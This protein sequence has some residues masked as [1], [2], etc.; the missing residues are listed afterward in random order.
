[1]K[2]LSATSHRP[3][4]LA[5]L[6]LQL[7]S[8]TGP[9]TEDFN[10]PESTDV[11]TATDPS[12]D[13]RSEPATSVQIAEWTDM[14]RTYQ[15]PAYNRC[16][17]Q[18]GLVED[19]EDYET[20]KYH[21]VDLGDIIQ[22]AQ[23][24]YRIVDKVGLKNDKWT[25]W[26]VWDI[27]SQLYRSLTIESAI[28][29][30]AG[31]K[32]RMMILQ[33]LKEDV[34]WAAGLEERMVVEKPGVDFIDAPYDLFEISG[35]NGLHL[36]YVTDVGTFSLSSVDGSDH[37]DDPPLIP[38]TMNQKVRLRL[39][40]ELC[41]AVEFLHNKDI[42]HG[43]I[44]SESVRFAY[45]QRSTA[46]NETT[47][48]FARASETLPV[49]RLDGSPLCAARD[50]GVPKRLV[51][52]Q[53]HNF[54]RWMRKGNEKPIICLSNFSCC[55]HIPFNSALDEAH[56]AYNADSSYDKDIFNLGHQCSIILGDGAIDLS[57]AS[58]GRS[59]DLSREIYGIKVYKPDDP[60]AIDDYVNEKW[61]DD[62]EVTILC[63]ILAMMA[64][65]RPHGKETISKIVNMLPRDWSSY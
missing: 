55:R 57:H 11:Q 2:Q 63:D 53:T 29:T 50:A 56:V 54:A 51:F 14:G 64:R 37:A 36:C 26:A 65:S 6:S 43:S 45:H 23:A 52:P 48:F 59:E 39:V 38:P 46:Q 58:N 18:E 22:G 33:M 10:P 60:F 17:A 41:K 21:P 9:P 1:M 7:E 25:Y 8:I 34:E 42:T 20:L 16:C 15:M 31:G 5:S 13:Y 40:M 44:D 12:L 3:L 30:A 47:E 4:P 27:D 35:P 19:P 24:R 62:E 49:K 28:H 32:E 61:Y